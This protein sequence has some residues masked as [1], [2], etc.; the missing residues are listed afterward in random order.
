MS[1]KKYPKDLLEIYSAT[2]ADVE[3][4]LAEIETFVASTN[5]KSFEVT[6]TAMNESNTL[7]RDFISEKSKCIEASVGQSKATADALNKHIATIA[8]IQAKMS[9]QDKA[10]ELLDYKQQLSNE[11]NDEVR[12]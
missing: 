4:K 11:L 7:I 1:D 12:I 3:L 6:S 5:L 2:K 8:S 9:G 10:K